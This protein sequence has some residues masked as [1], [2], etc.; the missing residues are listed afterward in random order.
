[1]QGF[2]SANSDR[3]TWDQGDLFFLLHVPNV[4]AGGGCS[5]IQGEQLDKPKGKARSPAALYERV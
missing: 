2:P 3:Q 5:D 4:L 1:M